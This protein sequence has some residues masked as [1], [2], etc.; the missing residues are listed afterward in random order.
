MLT[1][2]SLRRWLTW[3][4]S[5]A[6]PGPGTETT[7]AQAPLSRESIQASKLI[8]L[9]KIWREILPWTGLSQHLNTFWISTNL[10][11]ARFLQFQKS[12]QEEILALEFRK[13]DEEN[14]GKISE[15]NFADLLIAYAGF[16]PKKRSKM[17]RRVKKAFNEESSPGVDLTDYLNFYQAI[18]SIENYKKTIRWN[19]S[20]S[21]FHK[22]DRYSVTVLPHRRRSYWKIDYETCG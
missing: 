11:P 20:G 9:E 21:V 8:S 10:W 3:W 13:N 7:V 17:L 18:I 4:S 14:S 2:K 1:R 6:A 22:R 16:Q 15:K 5:T 12:L 19:F